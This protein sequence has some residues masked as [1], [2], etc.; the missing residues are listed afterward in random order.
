MGLGLCRRKAGACEEASQHPRDRSGFERAPEMGA[1][2]SDEEGEKDRRR[3]DR[4]AD[5][6]PRNVLECGA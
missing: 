4:R 5:P 1:V 3:V 6:L 2:K